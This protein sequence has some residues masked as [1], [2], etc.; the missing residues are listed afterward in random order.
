MGLCT[1]CEYLETAEFP[2][3]KILKRC[4][5]FNINIDTDAAKCNIYKKDLTYYKELMDLLR[6]GAILIDPSIQIIKNMDIK[7]DVN[8]VQKKHES[9]NESRKYKTGHYL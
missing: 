5:M 4:K 9:Y 8:E 6:L 7:D 2:N 3:G 1:S